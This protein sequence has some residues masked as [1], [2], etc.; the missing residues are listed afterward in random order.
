MLTQS[1]CGRE[2]L[3]REQP[4]SEGGYVV[5]AVFFANKGVYLSGA[6]GAYTQ[7]GGSGLGVVVT[8][9]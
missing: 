1:G 3:D 5:L 2:T 4:S 7:V 6:V 8:G 9:H